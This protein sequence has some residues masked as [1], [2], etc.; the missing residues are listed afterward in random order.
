MPTP[1][2]S[3]ETSLPIEAKDIRLSESEIDTVLSMLAYV[4]R[5]HKSK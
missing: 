3:S 1:Y 4:M 5:W 2:A